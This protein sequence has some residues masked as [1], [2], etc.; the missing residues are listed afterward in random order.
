M[1]R[2]R[3]SNGD[4]G[5]AAYELHA[6]S[7]AVHFSTGKVYVYSHAGAGQDHVEKMKILAGAGAGLNSYIMRNVRD[8]YD[9]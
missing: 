1:E 7:I 9:R 3:N 2:Y 5:I 6:D 8:R 4:S